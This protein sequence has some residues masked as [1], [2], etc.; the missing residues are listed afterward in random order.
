MIEKDENVVHQLNQRIASKVADLILLKDYPS[1]IPLKMA[2][3]YAG[4]QEKLFQSQSESIIN[5]EIKERFKEISIQ[6]RDSIKTAT[7]GDPTML[8]ENLK[9]DGDSFLHLSSQKEDY[10]DQLGNNLN[11]LAQLLLLSGTDT[12]L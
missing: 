8:I 1:S 5:S 11:E 4:A 9:D 12:Q 10:Y 2:L 7:E 6:W 3:E